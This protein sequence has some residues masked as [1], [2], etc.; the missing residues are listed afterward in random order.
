MFIVIAAGLAGRIEDAFDRCER[1]EKR[2]GCRVAAICVLGDLPLEHDFSHVSSTGKTP[3]VPGSPT[4]R[5][6][7]QRATAVA[8][9]VHGRKAPRFPLLFLAGERDDFALLARYRLSSHVLQLD[10]QLDPELNQAPVPSGEKLPMVY[11]HSGDM[12]EVALAG[13]S[14]RIGA[15]SM[16]GSGPAPSSAGNR[17]GTQRGGPGRQRR[18]SGPVHSSRADS[19]RLLSLA[20]GSLDLLLSHDAPDLSD[21]GDGDSD[22]VVPGEGPSPGALFVKTLDRVRP[23]LGIHGHGSRMMRSYTRGSTQVV[24]LPPW[25]V[26]RDA[27]VMSLVNTKRRFVEKLP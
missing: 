24:S 19:R 6:S 7:A 20:P 25:P 14:V 12:L 5:A 4:S 2:S 13:E 1:W 27:G 15:L 8:D 26:G 23:A 10:R 22:G 16:F 11:L 17:T 18:G 9:L 3:R 21:F